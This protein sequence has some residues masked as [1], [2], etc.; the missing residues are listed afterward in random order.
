MGTPGRIFIYL[1][2]LLSLTVNS[3]NSVMK[4]ALL[5][6]DIQDFYFPGGKSE[7]K[8]PELA[9][10]N[11]YLVLDTFRDNAETIVFIKHNYKPGGEIHHSV[12]PASF[13]KVITKDNINAFI[14]TGLDKFL[15]GEKIEALVI[16]GM[17]THM[18]VE[19][20][21]RAA[22]DLGYK[23]TVIHDACTTRDLKFEEIIVKARDVHLST[24]STL[25]SY[26]KIISTEEF[27]EN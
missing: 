20:A 22:S 27:I 16:C 26:A 7:L 1:F 15:K 17:Q 19:A 23:C 12:E 4:R 5:L 10:S 9:S 24:L 8:D 13:E 21:T 2:A 6:I 18:C 25:K 14:G 3:Q 11:A